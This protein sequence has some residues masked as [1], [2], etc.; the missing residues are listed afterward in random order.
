[1][2][3]KIKFPAHLLGIPDCNLPP[4]RPSHSVLFIL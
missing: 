3:V 4:Y 2:A 1:M